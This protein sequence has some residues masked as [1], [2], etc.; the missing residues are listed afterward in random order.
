MSKDTT[1]LFWVLGSDAPGN[2][3][4]RTFRAPSEH[5][6]VRWWTDTLDHAPEVVLSMNEL[7]AAVDSLAALTHELE[8]E[9]PSTQ[10]FGAWL[11]HV[12]EDKVAFVPFA[13]VSPEEVEWSAK[14][15]FPASHLLA[16]VDA[17]PLIGALARLRTIEKGELDVDEKIRT[18]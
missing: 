16:V 9:D 15:E 4:E 2:W 17:S 18:P 6:I 7:E 11:H 5:S 1:Q 3:H 8:E 10:L 13:S 12:D 14:A